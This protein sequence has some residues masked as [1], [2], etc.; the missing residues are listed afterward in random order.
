LA[1]AADAEAI[2]TDKQGIGPLAPKDGKCRI[3]LAG[4]GGIERTSIDTTQEPLA[5]L[6]LLY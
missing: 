3:D 4:G 6:S 1:T 5:I 2:A